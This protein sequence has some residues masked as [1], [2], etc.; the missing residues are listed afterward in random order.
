MAMVRCS[1]VAANRRQHRLMTA[2]AIRAS[3]RFLRSV[4]KAVPAPEFGVDTRRTLPF[5]R[6]VWMPEAKGQGCKR[7]PSALY[8]SGGQSGAVPA[9]V[10]GRGVKNATG[11]TREGRHETR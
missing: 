4:G 6:K 9:T 5:F 1:R 3:A 8:P 11:E 10:C 2:G 7:E